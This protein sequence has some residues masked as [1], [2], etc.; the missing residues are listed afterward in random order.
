MMIVK[1]ILFIF[2]AFLVI[3]STLT[4]NIEQAYDDLF[5][6]FILFAVSIAI[7]NI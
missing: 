3:K 4:K 1:T 7:Q 6:G 5:T 2:S